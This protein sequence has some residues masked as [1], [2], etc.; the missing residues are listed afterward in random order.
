MHSNAD[1][2]VCLVRKFPNDQDGAVRMNNDMVLQSFNTKARQKKYQEI[3]FKVGMF[4]RSTN[5]AI[6]K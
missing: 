4:T 6:C 3:A 2:G 5:A 1:S